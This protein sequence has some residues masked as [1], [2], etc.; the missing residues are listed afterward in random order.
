M[1]TQG[2]LLPCEQGSAV[3]AG[4]SVVVAVDQPPEAI[5]QARWRKPVDTELDGL[6][7]S[8]GLLRR[9]RYDIVRSPNGR[10]LELDDLGVLGV[11]GTLF[12]GRRQPVGRHCV[13][14]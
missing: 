5:L 11:K 14:L 10:R 1:L 7:Q 3:S 13:S 9:E 6:R 2:D 8:E 4:L 12:A